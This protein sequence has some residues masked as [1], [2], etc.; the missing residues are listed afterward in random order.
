MNS[1]EVRLGIFRL[2]IAVIVDVHTHVFPQ[3]NGRIASG[4]TRGLAWGRASVGNNQIWALPPFSEKVTFNW[5]ALIAQM[6]WA[7]VD[8][9]VML[10]GPYYGDC[11]QYA[12]QAVQSCPGRLAAA[13]YLDPWQETS[14]TAFETIAKQ[15]VFKAL[16]LELTVETGLCGL[17]PGAKLD[18]PEVTWLWASLQE[19]GLVLVLDL[20][21]VGS[22]SYQTQ[23]VRRIAE[24]H[25]R[26]KVVIAHLAQPTPAMDEDSKLQK[27]W[28]EQIDLGR[29]E[30][31]WFDT[32]AL[33]AY[34]PDEQYPYPTT[35][36][37]IKMAIERIGPSR[38][39]LGTD[40]P[41]LLLHATYPQL[42][43]LARLQT[44]FL[45]P[46]EQTMIMGGNA[47]NVFDL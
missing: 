1:T 7:G 16:K 19:S 14:R 30:N 42:I 18:A 3:I 6:D 25:P 15:R 29:L 32:A 24:N 27:L 39:M 44:Q 23:A 43:G 10:Q 11:N 33:P 46:K 34:L 5:E 26:L 31:V 45:C 2:V 22:P 28:Y 47:L 9:A 36:R 37:W 21:A 12:Q 35:I 40:I 20:G 8:K 17:H 41:G 38:I 13:A 4:L